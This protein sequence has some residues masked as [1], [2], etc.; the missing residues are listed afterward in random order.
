M[1]HRGLTGIG[2]VVLAA[3]NT[4]VFPALVA[5]SA[6]EAPPSWG[7]HTATPQPTQTGPLPHGP[8][9][10]G[11]PSTPTDTAAPTVPEETADT[12][13]AQDPQFVLLQSGPVTCDDP[14]RREEHRFD[15]Y[16]YETRPE[17]LMRVHGAGVVGGDFDDDGDVD[18]MMFSDRE[19]DYLRTRAGGGFDRNP[20]GW[21]EPDLDLSKGFGGSVVD[22]DADGDLDVFVTRYRRR[23]VLLENDGLGNFRDVAQDRGLAYGRHRSASSAWADID[24][25][26]DLDVVVAGHGEILEDGS[27]VEDF[28]P[29]NPTLLYLND[30]TGHFQEH[31]ELIPTDVHDAFSFVASW[32]DV[33]RDGLPDLYMINDFGGR[34]QSCRLLW[35]RDGSF[36]ADDNVAGLDLSVSGMGLGIGDIDEDGTT[37]FLVPAWGRNKLMLG[38][39]LGLWVDHAQ[40]LGMEADDARNQVVGWGGE[41]ADIDNDTRLDSVVVYGAIHTTISPTDPGA[42]RCPVD[43]AAR[44]HLCGRRRGLGGVGRGR[45]PRRARGRPQPRRLAGCGQ[46]RHR[47]AQARVHLALWR[48]LVGEHRAAGTGTQHPRHWGTRDGHLW[49]TDAGAD[50]GGRRHQLRHGRAARGTLWTR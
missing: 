1:V 12:A 20:P 34:L 25:D 35:N 41:L 31:P 32:V 15:Q 3:C 19:W 18:V 43:P 39:E 7:P 44:W 14:T 40:A 49:G 30:G 47:R 21:L 13:D 27:E 16:T 28:A 42:A 45:G 37:D 17:E 4:V 5:P 46:A 9:D 38:T 50:R 6:V 33:D 2:L 23:N 36:V 11:Q 22:Y 29:G 10:T 48:G 26:G 24:A 8:D